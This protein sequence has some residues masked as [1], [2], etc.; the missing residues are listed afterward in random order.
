M[1]ECVLTG[2]DPDDPAALTDLLFNPASG[3]RRGWFMRLT[4]KERMIANP[5][6]IS[7]VTIFSTFL[8]D[9][10]V[11]GSAGNAL[12]SKTGDSRIYAVFTNTADAV[13]DNNGI[14][15]RFEDIGN[16]TTPVFTEQSA[17]KNRPGDTGGANNADQLDQ[18]LIDVMN[19]LKTMFPKNC[20]FA[21]YRIDVKTI[22]AD[23]GI[24]FIAPVPICI[25]EKNWKEF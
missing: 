14:S 10:N 16:F 22:A 11:T 17:T 7:G 3:L 13:F 21:N 19:T 8:P 5:F 23:T 24:H 2:V 15:S 18:H 25:V 12:C 20:K 4:T 1:N 9:V 6:A